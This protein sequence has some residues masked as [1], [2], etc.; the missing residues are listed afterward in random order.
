MPGVSDSAFRSACVTS[1]LR[2]HSIYRGYHSSDFSYQIAD[3]ETWCAVEVNTAIMCACMQSL[4]PLLGRINA[5]WRTQARK[6]NSTSTS[7]S[8][9]IE[10]KGPRLNH[11][12]DTKSTMMDTMTGI[13]LN[14]AAYVADRNA[15]N[16]R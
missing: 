6:S 16:R 15:H 4:K 11:S 13:E 7:S 2:L 12:N 9:T 1:I 8:S 3:I 10:L 5:R 14:G